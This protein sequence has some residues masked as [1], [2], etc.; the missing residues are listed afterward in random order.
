MSGIADAIENVTGAWILPIMVGLPL[1]VAVVLVVARRLSD[2][3][4]T[5]VAASAATVTFVLAIRASIAAGPYRDGE[6]GPRTRQILDSRARRPAS[7]SRWTA[8]APPCVLLTALL[9]LLVCCAQRPGASGGRAG[10]GCSSPATSPSWAAPSRRSPRWTPSCSSSPSRS[11]WCRCGSSSPCGVTTTQQPFDAAA[12]P[13][14]ARWRGGPPGRREPVPPVHRDRLGGDAARP[15]ARGAARGTTDLAGCWPSAPAKGSA[16]RS[17]RSRPCSSS[18]GLAVK[19]P[20]FGVHTWLPPAH[21][22]APTG[23]S[24]LLAGVLLKM[25]YLRSGAGRRPDRCRTASGPSRRCWPLLGV[26]GILWAGLACFVQTDLKRLIALLDASAHMGFVLLGI[27]SMTPQG[28]QGALFANVA[29]GLI[30]GLL[31][32]IVGALKDR[33]HTADL[34]LIGGGTARPGATAGLAARLRRDRRAGPAGSGRVLGRTARDHRRLAVGGRASSRGLRARRLRRGRRRRHRH[35][36][37]LPAAGAAAH[38]ARRPPSGRAAARAC[39]SPDADAVTRLTVAAPLM[40]AHRSCPTV[41]WDPALAA[42]R[43]H[44]A[45]GPGAPDRVRR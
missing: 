26:A 40:V 17:R 14:A 33:H 2:D 36:R 5:L 13:A 19:V 34:A 39:R 12:V 22:I 4:A 21:T 25:G 44:R 20:A 31:F 11:C 9:G 42:A 10:R 30:T 24:M 35:R 41:A 32:L 16:P 7:T 37:R 18:F 23:G 38:L 29:H 43:P 28:L 1:I 45:C 27:A 3:V 6:H 15:A 8:S